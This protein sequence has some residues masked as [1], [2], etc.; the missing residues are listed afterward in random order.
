[1]GRGQKQYYDYIM[2]YSGVEKQMRAKEG[3][4]MTIFLPTET[5]TLQILHVRTLNSA[6]ARIDHSLLL[7][8]IKIKFKP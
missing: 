2:I 1:M 8:K 7:A 4:A 6:D 5:S 3:I